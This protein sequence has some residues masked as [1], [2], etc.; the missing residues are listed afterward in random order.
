MSKLPTDRHPAVLWIPLGLTLALGIVACRSEGREVNSSMPAGR[1]FV[2]ATRPAPAFAAAPAPVPALASRDPQSA[3]DL[4]GPLW[5]FGFEILNRQASKSADDLVFSPVSLAAVLALTLDGAGGSTAAELRAALGLEDLPLAEV[6][7]SW[8]NLIGFINGTE[9]SEGAV[10]NSLWLTGGAS[11]LPG[12]ATTAADAFAAEVRTLPENPE[13][14]RL[15]VNQWLGRPAASE[16]VQ[17]A[18]ALVDG[19]AHRRTGN[20]VRGLRFA[21]P[22]VV[23]EQA[24]DWAARAVGHELFGVLAALRLHEARAA[25]ELHAPA[26][27]AAAAHALLG[28]MAEGYAPAFTYTPEAGLVAGKALKLAG[29]TAAAD[30][31]LRD[32]VDWVRR[33][34]LPQVPAPFIDSFLHRNPVNRELLAR[35]GAAARG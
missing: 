1:P 21:A 24:E 34:A 28:L 3:G 5:E 7:R 4:S 27:A 25:T 14:A 32:A 33:R 20:A 12:F 22:Q 26:R 19:D 2:A 31:A 16:S 9:R 18:L 15:E 30:R 23:L 13:E 11:V 35:A 29:E 6:N 10:A 8:A 17:Q